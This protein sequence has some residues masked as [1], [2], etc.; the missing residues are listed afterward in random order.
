[1][2]TYPA[3]TIA[4]NST[5]G[6]EFDLD[7]LIADLNELGATAI[8]EQPDSLRAFFSHAPDR[9]AALAS[10][11]PRADLRC[12]AIDVPDEN[13]AERSQAA[14]T[15]V[16]IGA[17]TVA[18]P[19]TVT[20][21]LRARSTRSPGSEDPGL[22]LIVIQPSMGFGTGH[23]ASTRLCLD[24]LQRTPVGGAS[25]LDVGTGSGVLAIAASILGAADIVGIDVDP[26]ALT[27]A[28]ENGGLNGA[29]GARVVWEELD[30]SAAASTLGR[31]FHVIC[32]N[33][34]GGLLFRDAAAFGGLAAPGA[35]LIASGFQPHEAPHV[36]AAFKAAGW[37]LDG[38]SE[39]DDWVGARLKRQ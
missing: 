33:L 20:D 35:A 8:D 3:I 2:R 21:D 31:T 15:P 27:A 18:P 5:P 25:V 29:A 1:M 32:A 4:L 17:I 9:D 16:T 23:H 7:L 37:S 28:R 22:R 10:L 6:V 11:R 13:W 26:D 39:E 34:T 38:H 30:L 24:W 36:I 19:W 14:L 12:A